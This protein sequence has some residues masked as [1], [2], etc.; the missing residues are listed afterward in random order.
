MHSD[1][2]GAAL[3]SGV[4]TGVV[5]AIPEA[6]L[7][8][9]EKVLSVFFLAVVAEIGRRLVHRLWKGKS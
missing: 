6:A 4:V 1:H 7:S 2:A 5:V 3:V 8:Y 9:G